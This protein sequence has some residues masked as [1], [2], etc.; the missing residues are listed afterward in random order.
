[1]RDTRSCG[2]ARAWRSGRYGNA[3]SGLLPQPLT[4]HT[5]GTLVADSRGTAF[6]SHVHRATQ[7]SLDAHLVLV[8][9]RKALGQHRRAAAVADL[10]SQRFPTLD[11]QRFAARQP[12]TDP[13]VLEKW[14]ADLKEAGIPH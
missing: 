10:V 12:F 3:C 5:P 4:A 9:A 13:A 11:L 14:L 6:P 1:M 7:R 2:T 8:A